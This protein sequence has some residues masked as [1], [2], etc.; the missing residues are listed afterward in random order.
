MTMQ[1]VKNLLAGL[2]LALVATL[3]HAQSEYRVQPGDGLNIEVLEDSSLNRS[4]VV[5]PD[6]RFNFPFAG[7]ILAAGRNAVQI[8]SAVTTAIQSNFSNPP[9]V[10]VSVAPSA[11]NAADVE[12]DGEIDVYFLGEVNTPGVIS[13][14]PGTTLLQAIAVGGGVTR[15]AAIKRIQVRRTNP[16]TGVQNVITL[17]Y[18]ALAKGTASNVIELKDGDVILV[19][20]RRLFE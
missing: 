8:Q 13:V 12:K 10:F 2:M 20:E 1:N 6:G 18:K 5:L 9:T 14:E 11:Q 7:T 15:F 3:A 16:Q 19:P 17:N 4:V